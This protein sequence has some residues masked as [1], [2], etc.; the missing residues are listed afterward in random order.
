MTSLRTAFRHSG[1]GPIVLFLLVLAACGG[2]PPPPPSTAPA[3]DPHAGH[4][5]GSGA[6][7]LPEQVQRN[8][9]ITWA[10]A[11]YR[12]VQGVLRMPGRFE[13]EST[14]R[15]T[16]LAPASGRVE[17]LVAPY[18]RVAAGMPLYRLHAAEW[19]RLQLELAEAQVA[20]EA[21]PARLAAVEEQIAALEAAIGQW[22]KRQEILE[23]LG[24]E[25]GGSAT[26]VAEAAAR[27][28]EL[29]VDLAQ[30]RRD[31]ADARSQAGE[32]GQARLRQR[33]LL[34]QA[35]QLTGRSEAELVVAS[36][37][38][39]LW[40]ALPAVE[41]RARGAGL[42]EG[43]VHADGTWAEAHEAVLTV[44]DPTGVRLRAAG[45]QADLPR[46]RDGL[47]ARIVASD[48]A[49]AVAI[50]ATLVIGPVADAIDRSVDLIARPA[51]GSALPAWVRPGVTANLEVVINGGADEELAIPL[52][53]TIRDGLKTLFYRRD[54]R[55]PDAV[56]AVEADL[57]A[58][59]GRWVAVLSGLKEGDQVVLGGIYPLKL[60]Q[61][62]GGSQAGHFDP[63]GTFH[64][65]KH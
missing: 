3:A 35:A 14:A 55:D 12:V 37:G 6:I 53:A 48:P 23:R 22:R 9:G 5:H 34:A 40:A 58:R 20:V 10:T 47:P 2:D 62:Q 56:V 30:A 28:A 54:P 42:V 31:F 24:R 15:H 60:S 1:G 65:G 26:E 46:L 43:E 33:L 4:D 39:P 49:V 25:L 52:A 27:S 13:A 44:T 61:Q 63:D 17:L 38:L 7:A 59:D 32:S 45:L 16:Y 8:L 41:V 11:E 57:G 19:R 64:T 29:H 18:Q 50:P 51:P 36:N 21:A